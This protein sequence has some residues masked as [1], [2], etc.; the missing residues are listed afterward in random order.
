MDPKGPGKEGGTYHT[1]FSS[2]YLWAEASLGYELNRYHSFLERRHQR[3]YAE[4]C[5][6]QSTSLKCGAMASRHEASAISMTVW[7]V[8]CASWTLMSTFRSI[9]G[10]TKWLQ[11]SN[12]WRWPWASKGRSSEWGTP[13]AAELTNWERERERERIQAE[14]KPWID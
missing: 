11:C 3:R 5:Y 12:W 6:V 13:R 8:S 14:E 7:K 10:P 9:L 4:R 1:A 2:I